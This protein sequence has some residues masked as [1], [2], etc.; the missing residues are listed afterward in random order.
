MRWKRWL[1]IGVLTA[2]VAVVGGPFAYIHFIEG[3]VAAPLALSTAQPAQVSVQG[4]LDGTWNIAS[5][6]VAG[7]RVKEVLFG[8]STTAVGR[9]SSMSGSIVVEGTT[10][11][12]GTVTVD[13]TSVASD[14]SMRDR[15][16]Q[17]RIMETSTYP[18]ATFTF[19]GPVDVGSVPAEGANGTYTV[20]GKLTLHG[21]TRTVTVTLAGRRTGSQI[22]VSG[23]IPVT[24]AD[25]NIA[26]PSFGPA[27]TED[28]GV[29]EFALNFAHA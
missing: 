19:D 9:T 20:T 13:L 16:F 28:H 7:Y 22:Q 2:V 25:Y 12:S 5:G 18:T 6:S 1:L 10:V 17:G 29:L 8:Q 3:K 4:S 27:Q 24:F 21:T 26:N 11:K 23:S 15:Q 14:K